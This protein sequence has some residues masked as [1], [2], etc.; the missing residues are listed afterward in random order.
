MLN[1]KKFPDLAALR[2]REAALKGEIV[3]SM[4]RII[5]TED[6]RS[7]L[8]KDPDGS[9]PRDFIEFEGR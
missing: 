4:N 3:F 2:N 9:I 5:A 6:M 1:S 8:S 7:K